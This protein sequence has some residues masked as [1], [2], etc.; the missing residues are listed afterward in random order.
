M[1]MKEVFQPD[2]LFNTIMT[3]VF[4]LILLSVLWLIGCVP[5]ITIGASTSALYYVTMKMVE[6]RDSGIIRTFAKGYKENLKKSIPLTLLLLLCVGVLAV[7]FH[8][9]GSAENAGAS[10]MYGG[11]IA[12]AFILAAVYGYVFPLL[13]K[14]E[15]TVKNT[16]ANGAKLA[17]THLPQTLLIT[18]LNLLPGVWFLVS[19]GTF[20]MIFWIWVF[21]GTGVVA[22]INSIFLIRIFN[23][24]IEEQ[25]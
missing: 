12:L 18:V 8:V 11:C 5:I 13:A 22:Y 19:P 23:I 9:L 15:N 1:K 25:N 21:A 16:L 20:S 7:D 14:F 10:V 24:L 6:D 2:N 17:I 3:K 4:D